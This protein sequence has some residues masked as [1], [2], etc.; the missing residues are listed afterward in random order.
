[1]ANGEWAGQTRVLQRRARAGASLAEGRRGGGSN[2][3]VHPKAF[4]VYKNAHGR[5]KR[6]LFQSL[7]PRMTVQ[8]RMPSHRTVWREL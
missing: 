3:L 8:D 2:N 6:K 1:M 5:S 7:P 4:P